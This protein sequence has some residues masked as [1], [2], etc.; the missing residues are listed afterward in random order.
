MVSATVK[1]SQTGVEETLSCD[2]FF[3][4]MPIKH[5]VKM[6]TPSAPENVREIGEGCAIEISLLSGC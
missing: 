6:I 4:T 3:S 5:L 1:N 2:Y